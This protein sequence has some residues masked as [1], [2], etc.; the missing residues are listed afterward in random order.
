MFR[1]E[2]CLF[3]LDGLLLDTEPLHGKAWAQAAI[4]FGKALSQN[5]LNLLRG[6]RRHECAQQILTWIDKPVDLKDFLAV[7]E[8]I[9]KQLL[10]QAKAMVGAEELIRWCSKNKLPIALVTS[11]TSNSVDFKSAPHSWLELIV[12]RVLGDDKTLLNGKPEPDPYLLAAQKLSVDPKSCWALEDS[13]SG[14]NSALRAGCQV[15][16]LNEKRTS[17][18]SKKNKE[19]PNPCYIDKLGFVLEELKKIW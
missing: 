6:R 17:F 11:S 10:R 19:I 3:D 16:V 2:A 4:K 7:H 18:I 5:Q 1:P 8:P 12:T 9:S 14:T 15:W 13:L